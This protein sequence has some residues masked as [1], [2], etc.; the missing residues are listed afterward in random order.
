VEVS[1]ELKLTNLVE[2]VKKA[3]QDFLADGEGLI[4]E[5][6]IEDMAVLARLTTE[7]MSELELTGVVR[8]PEE[9]I[10]GAR[11]RSE[12]AFS[13]VDAFC[14]L[15]STYRAMGGKLKEGSSFQGH[16]NL[17]SEFRLQYQRALQSRDFRMRLGL[18]LTAFRTQLMIA[19]A[20]YGCF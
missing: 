8:G 2:R 5:S 16:Q 15:V 3:Q 4:F 10:A 13:G 19:V 17:E 12:S 14:A 9:H 20:N 7:F 1:A 11:Y 18:L 6:D